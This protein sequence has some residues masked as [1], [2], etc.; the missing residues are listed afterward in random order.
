MIREYVSGNERVFVLRDLI[1]VRIPENHYRKMAGKY[2]REYIVSSGKPRRVLHHITGRDLVYITRESGIPLLG[3]NAFGIIDRGNTLLQIRPVTGC[4]LN[5][6]FCSVDEGRK[7]KTRVTDFIVEP[8]YLSQK[9][10]EV[11]EYKGNGLEAHIDG[12]GEP[13]LYPYMEDLLREIRKIGEISTISIQTNGSLLNDELIEVMEKY[14]DRINLSIMTLNPDSIS[15]IY[16]AGYPLERVRE[17]AERIALNTKLDLLIAPV[18]LPGINDG[19]IKKIIDFALEIGAGKR[20]P[21]LGIQKY[22]PH[23]FGRKLKNWIS[24]KEFYRQLRI[25]EREYGIKLILTPED[26]G[27]ERRRRLPDPLKKGEIYRARVV[28]R[29]RLS[30]ERLAVVNERIVSI[31]SQKNPGKYVKFRVTRVKDGLYEGVEVS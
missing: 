7:S 19:D 11:A 25:W 14:V 18:W 10:R 17:I 2:S 30:F 13:L 23:R 15:R 28:S 27:I 16:N 6:I 4:N 22:I 12:Q 31:R 26:F 5:C 9:V 8:E 29:G 21:P 3:Y 1:E 20:A 24:F